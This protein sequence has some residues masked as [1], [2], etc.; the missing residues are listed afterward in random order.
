MQGSTLVGNTPGMSSYTNVTSEPSR[1]ALN[2]RTLFTPRGNGIVVIPVESIRAISERFANT[3]YGIFLGKWVAYPF[4]SMEDVSKKPTASTSG[5]KKKGVEPTKEVSNSNPF[6]VLHSVDNDVKFGT[7]EGTSNLASN[8]ANPSGSSFWNVETSSTSTTS[9]VDKIGKLEKLIIDEKATLVDDAGKPVKQFE[10]LDD[11]D[12]EDEVESIDN[13]MARFMASE[14]VGFGTKS[15][16]EQ[17]RD[18]YE[19][20]D[21][22]EDSYDDDMYEGQDLP[23][24]IQD[25]CDKLDIRVRGRSYQLVLSLRVLEQKSSKKGIDNCSERRDYAL[26]G[27]SLY[28]FLNPGP[29]LLLIEEYGIPESRE[30]FKTTP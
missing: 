5:N 29:V 17:W 4:S 24:K 27:A 14:R 8:G 15:L 13:D 25:I 3:S 12:S 10:Y 16:L 26:F 1:K 21:Y 19:N 23:D 6:N 11:H 2:F 18:S 20:G 9:I 28:V 30:F 7:D 22:D